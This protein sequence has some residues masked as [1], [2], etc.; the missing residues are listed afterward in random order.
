MITNGALAIFVKTPGVSPIKTRL[1]DTIGQQ[2][3]N[4]FYKLSLAATSAVAK[5]LQTKLPDLQ[6]FWA[7][8]E[9]ESLCA[10][11]WSDFP[12]VFQGE[13]SLGHRLDFV[14]SEL[15]KRYSYVCF[16]GA[17]SPHISTEQI[18]TGIQLTSK[19]LKRRFVVGETIDGGFYFFGGSIPLSTNLWHSVK[20]STELT[21]AQLKNGLTLFGGVELLKKDFD[22]DTEGD[23]VRYSESTFND[24][25]FLLEQLDIINW[26]R[27]F[28]RGIP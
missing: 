22:I 15:L 9:E 13:G 16:L 19:Y 2:A 18:E 17:D 28:T 14:Y 6:I 7:V 20:Y 10:T 21:F 25:N 12:T 4:H 11:I 5:K 27:S 26:A 8:A 3:A 23:L 1:G 24:S